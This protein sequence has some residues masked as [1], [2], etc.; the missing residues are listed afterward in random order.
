MS[1]SHLTH[2]RRV[3]R[4][5]HLD[6][7]PT[8]TLDGQLHHHLERAAALRAQRYQTGPRYGQEL[9]AARKARRERGAALGPSF[10]PEGRR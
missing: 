5:R 10:R 7:T 3:T 8:V 1:R 9:A 2:R 4:R 6:L